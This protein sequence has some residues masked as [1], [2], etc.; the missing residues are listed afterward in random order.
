MHYDISTDLLR[1]AITITTTNT[2][3]ANDLTST[4]SAQE[5]AGLVVFLCRHAVEGQSRSAKPDAIRQ[6]RHRGMAKTA[7]DS[8]ATLDKPSLALACLSLALPPCDKVTVPACQDC[9]PTIPLL[10]CDVV[11]QLSDG[12]ARDP[13]PES[14]CLCTEQTSSRDIVTFPTV[15]A[16]AVTAPAVTAQVV[17]AF[18]DHPALADLAV[19]SFAELIAGEAPDINHGVV[20]EQL[21]KRIAVSPPRNKAGYVR[22]AFRAQQQQC[23]AARAM[24]PPMFSAKA[25]TLPLKPTS[26]E[27]ICKPIKVA[28]FTPAEL[29]MNLHGCAALLAAVAGRTALVLDQVEQ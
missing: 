15:T 24:Q 11:T 22:A 29:E 8:V 14:V 5:L 20:A 17:S 27:D 13:D 28:G 10:P 4:F 9:G 7:R 19:P 6:R 3:A 1:V 12:L 16:P 25:K 21:A 2:N 26:R 18:A 23:L